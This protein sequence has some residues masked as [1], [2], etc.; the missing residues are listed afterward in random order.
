MSVVVMDFHEPLSTNK[1]GT[2]VIL[3]RLKRELSVDGLAF[4]EKW[5]SKYRSETDVLVALDRLEEEAPRILAW[6]SSNIQQM[7]GEFSSERVN[8][9]LGMRDITVISGEKKGD[10]YI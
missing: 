1:K 10:L 8:Y 4:F 9:V 2:W 3:W 5:A 6:V 7:I